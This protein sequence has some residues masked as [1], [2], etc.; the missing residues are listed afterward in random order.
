[1]MVTSSSSTS[2]RSNVRM[3]EQEGGDGAIE[4]REVK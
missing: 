1:M 2:G 3:M 4:E